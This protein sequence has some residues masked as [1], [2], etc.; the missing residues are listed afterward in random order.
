MATART[1]NA[2]QIVLGATRRSRLTELTRGSVINR[3]IRDSGVGLDVHVISRA[4][5]GERAPRPR[6]RAA[7][8]RCRGGA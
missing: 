1:L 5:D 8:A 3:V 7:P 2:T 4:E 6:G